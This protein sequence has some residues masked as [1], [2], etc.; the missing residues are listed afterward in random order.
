[1]CKY[2][3]KQVKIFF[4]SHVA[5]RA[6][7]LNSSKYYNFRV[8]LFKLKIKYVFFS[9]IKISVK[10]NHF[11]CIIVFQLIFALSRPTFSLETKL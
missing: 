7:C 8:I 4:L 10:T 1:M 2:L 11:T 5:V 3:F 6:I 9:N